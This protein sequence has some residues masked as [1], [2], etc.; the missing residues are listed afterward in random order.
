MK[1]IILSVLGHDRPG[2]LAAVSELLLENG[3]NIENAS[4]TILQSVFG[5]LL[6]VT[7]PEDLSPD[8]LK[9]RMS[10]SLAGMALDIFIKEHSSSPVQETGV[11]PTEAFIITAFGPDQPGLVSAVSRCVANHGI[12][13]S[14]LRAVF[15]GG[16][17]PGNNVMIFEV[18]IPDVADLKQV[19][20][21]LDKV[22]AR[23]NL[24]INLQHRGIFNAM[25][26]I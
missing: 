3:C 17:E 16:N 10:K 26:R 14:N 11:Q 9:S 4:Q 2:I 1:K 8:T 5:S 25:N 6:L 22:A 21:D 15:K 20:D 18:D 24:T 19:N 23:L 7:L 12:N 13:I